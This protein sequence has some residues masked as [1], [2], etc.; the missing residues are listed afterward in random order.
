MPPRKRTASEVP[1]PDAATAKRM[2]EYMTPSDAPEEGEYSVEIDKWD[3]PIKDL[4][5]PQT[6][7]YPLNPN[8]NGSPLY[9]RILYV[10]GLPPD[11]RKGLRKFRHWSDDDIQ[12][13]L[14]YMAVALSKIVFK[15]GPDFDWSRVFS[16]QHIRYFQDHP[17]LKD[18]PYERPSMADIRAKWKEKVIMFPTCATDEGNVKY[19]QILLHSGMTKELKKK[20][21][22]QGLTADD[23][24]AH[25]V[26]MRAL[27]WG[28]SIPVQNVAKSK[29]KPKR[30]EFEEF[31]EN[32]TYEASENEEPSEREEE[33]E[34]E[35]RAMWEAQRKAN[36]GEGPITV[37]D[38]EAAIRGATQAMTD[39]ARTTPS[40]SQETSGPTPRRVETLRIGPVQPKPM[41]AEE[42]E[43]TAKLRT[44]YMSWRHA[45]E[46]GSDEAIINQL[47]VTL[48]NLQIDL[49]DPDQMKEIEDRELGESATNVWYDLTE[50]VLTYQCLVALYI[51]VSDQEA[52]HEGL[53]QA[54][55]YMNLFDQQDIELTEEKVLEMR[56]FLITS[57]K[58]FDQMR[59]D[60]SIGA[61]TMRAD[62]GIKKEILGQTIG[63]IYLDEDQLVEKS[64]RYEHMVTYYGTFPREELTE[65][66]DRITEMMDEVDREHATRSV[67]SRGS[68]RYS[69][70]GTGMDHYDEDTEDDNRAEDDPDVD[71]G[72]VQM[73]EDNLVRMDP[74]NGTGLH[75]QTV[76]SMGRDQTTEPMDIN[77]TEQQLSEPVSEPGSLQSKDPNQAQIE[78]EPTPHGQEEPKED[79]AKPPPPP[80]PKPHRVTD[81]LKPSKVTVNTDDIVPYAGGYRGGFRIDMP[82][83]P[84]PRTPKIKQ[85]A[86]KSTQQERTS[87]K[88]TADPKPKGPGKG[89]R[90][91]SGKAI[92]PK[93]KGRDSRE[94]FSESEDTFYDDYERVK[95]KV[96]RRPPSKRLAGKDAEELK[97]PSRQTPKKD[98]PKK[99]K[100]DKQPP[101]QSGTIMYSSPDTWVPLVFITRPHPRPSTI[102][103]WTTGD[104]PKVVAISQGTQASGPPRS[105]KIKQHEPFDASIE[106]DPGPGFRKAPL[107]RTRTSEASDIMKKVKKAAR[108]DRNRLIEQGVIPATKAEIKV[109]D[110]RNHFKPSALALAEIRHYQETE[111]LLLSPT[112]VKRL[113]LEIAREIDEDYQFEGLAYRLLHKAGEEYLMRIYKDCALVASLQNRV[114]VDERDML[115]VRRISGDYGKFHTWGTG[116]QQ[117]VQEERMDPEATKV[118]KTGYK[119]Q[120]SQWKE[121]WTKEKNSHK[122]P[123][124]S[125]KKK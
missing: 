87:G 91:G 6:V 62:L 22:A 39:V 64:D 2:A 15:Q 45:S 83:P 68:A 96:G 58:S 88:E 72:L 122:Q 104:D 54:K 77:L 124:S 18:Q 33:R 101:P 53:V 13:H 56:K 8:G 76:I 10:F 115:V 84:P 7:V 5:N 31:P 99:K 103:D 40:T 110:K 14:K 66:Q 67:V 82:A 17:V 28:I 93:N 100:K 79:Q 51:E 29:Y 117:Y 125:I 90:R 34:Q 109:L 86:R 19:R 37:E 32:A 71:D 11:F 63:T 52:V 85:T 47:R 16:E 44:A 121:D 98:D 12:E 20:L 3:V 80:P 81:K 55:K 97:L 23:I 59:V 89:A 46:E 108:E 57:Q 38:M 1:F 78:P 43:N 60:Q 95:G 107:F 27:F 102:Q 50:F 4:A 49:Y 24:D 106:L 41:T 69:T 111:G 105:R 61:K 65:A 25:V 75:I 116:Y 123:K 9:M 94:L 120:F 119:S 118:S 74:N 48:G 114:T 42:L 113:C 30:L 36:L 92:A 70:V 35:V 112:V 73:E 26:H 21:M